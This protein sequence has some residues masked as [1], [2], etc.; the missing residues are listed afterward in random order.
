MTGKPVP[1]EGGGAIRRAARSSAAGFSLVEVLIAIVVLGLGL[2]GLA[3]VFPAI[4]AQQREATDQIQG[5]LAAETAASTL[6]VSA[7]LMNWENLLLDP[8]WPLSSAVSFECLG[9]T[10]PYVPRQGVDPNDPMEAGEQATFWH[11]RDR[12]RNFGPGISLNLDTGVVEL[13]WA[14]DAGGCDPTQVATNGVVVPTG[15]FQPNP[16]SLL[17]PSSRVIPPPFSGS[18]PRYVWDALA[19]R[20]GANE[21]EL[22]VFVRRIQ[23]LRLR[24]GETVSK[25]LTRSSGPLLPVSTGGDGT[26]TYSPPLVAEA[27]GVDRGKL[28]AER[29]LDLI[30]VQTPG[31]SV[32]GDFLDF[33]AGADDLPF[34]HAVGQRFVDNLGV[35][36]TVT[37]VVEEGGQTLLRVDPPYR[38]RELDSG[39]EGQG[40]SQEPPG[41]VLPV[42]QRLFQIVFTREAPAQIVVRKVSR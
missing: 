33:A 42:S 40:T 13:A 16:P 28:R 36:R 20:T 18:E 39:T 22:A 19:R 37:E 15:S 25:A 26:G 5:M 10:F 38:A 29:R 6:Q 27:W 3:S 41:P 21:V 24:T 30:R 4:I 23:P 17:P 32:H 14:I 2:L 35:V 34:L 31:S 12:S 7:D 8:R 11:I 9:G 1:C